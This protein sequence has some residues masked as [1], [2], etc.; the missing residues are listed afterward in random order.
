MKPVAHVLVSALV[1]LCFAGA[2]HAALTAKIIGG[3]DAIDNAYPFMAVLVSPLTTPPFDTDF[4]TQFCGGTVVAARWV[5]TAA[6]CVTG[7][8][9]QVIST[10]EIAVITGVTTLSTTVADNAPRI[11]VSNILRHPQY[12]PNSLQNDVALL[13]LAADTSVTVGNFAINDGSLLASLLPGADLTAIGWGATTQDDPA[14]PDVNETAYPP[15]L[16]EVVLDYIPFATCNGPDYHNG[17][18]TSDALCAGFL[19]T[20]PPRDTCFGDSGGPLLSDIGGAQPTWRQVGI[21]SYG[22]GSLCAEQGNPG[23]YANVGMFAGYINGAPVQADLHVAITATPGSPTTGNQLIARITVSNLSPANTAADTVLSITPATNM[24]ITNLATLAG[25]ADNSGVACDL[26]N[27]A[28]GASV[29]RD[30]ELQLAGIGQLTLTATASTT[31]GDYYATN[32]SAERAY[33]GT[34]TTTTTTTHFTSGGGGGALHL[35]LAALVGGLRRWR[36]PG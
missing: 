26:G 3:K 20:P 6:H 18:L 32:N 2:A 36:R 22:T 17:T 33:I 14:T 35:L 24:T 34:T 30:V 23:V 12:N 8:N 1:A 11:A 9:N 15:T 19:A 27:I 16:Q 25:C 10:S 4:Q 5:L 13:Y 31:T 29:F 28:P 21:T 7:N